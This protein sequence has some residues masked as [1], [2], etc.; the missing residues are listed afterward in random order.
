M[1]ALFQVGVVEQPELA[2][3]YHFVLLA[4]PQRFNGQPQLLLGLVH[5][6]VVEVGNPGM[7]LQDGLHHAEVVLPGEQF[8]V[9]ER[10]R[11]PRFAV[12]A[13]RQLDV[14]FTLAV[15]R[16]LGRGQHLFDV[17]SE[18][19]GAAHD[20]LEHRPRQAEHRASGGRCHRVLP[21]AVG[22]DQRLG[23][24]IVPG[25]KDAEQCWDAVFPRPV[26]SPFPWATKYT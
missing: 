4:L 1:D 3:V 8:V 6:V 5:R 10:P 19:V 26:R 17:G 13:G 14:G 9:H 15:V 7:H 2:I 22:F 23:T 25:T 18:G 21:G 20:L 12:M 24:E 11:Q 16:L